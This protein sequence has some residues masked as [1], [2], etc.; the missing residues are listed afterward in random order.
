MDKGIY[1]QKQMNSAS[2]TCTV[3]KM[4][5]IGGMAS[6]EGDNQVVF[7]N[8]NGPEIWPDKK[9]GI[10][11]EWPYKRGGLWWEWPYKRGTIVQW[12]DVNI[13]QWEKNPT[14]SQVK[15]KSKWTELS[16]FITCLQQ[17]MAIKKIKMNG[18]VSEQ[19]V[20]ILVHFLTGI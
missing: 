18:L 3:V 9:G 2:I 13:S 7:Y 1:P 14:E 8:L 16:A 5:P 4:W 19:N 6:L 12:E 11:W 20:V 17:T 10:W 15:I